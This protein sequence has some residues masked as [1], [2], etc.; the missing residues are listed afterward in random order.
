MGLVSSG[1]HCEGRLIGESVRG[2]LELKRRRSKTKRRSG[3]LRKGTARSEYLILNVL[4]PGRELQ[5]RK[6]QKDWRTRDQLQRG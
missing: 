1:H 3:T 4:A 6:R 5:S 2:T